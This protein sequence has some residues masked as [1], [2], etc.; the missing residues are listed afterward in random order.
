MNYDDVFDFANF[1]SARPEPIAKTMLFTA[2]IIAVIR[3]KTWDRNY[4]R[5]RCSGL[6]QKIY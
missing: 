2:F 1:G 3:S 5:F 4:R 6:M